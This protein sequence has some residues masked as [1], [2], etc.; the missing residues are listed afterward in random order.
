MRAL[1]R[2]IFVN[3]PDAGSRLALTRVTTGAAVLQT[4]RHLPPGELLD[5][6]WPAEDGKWRLSPG[7]YQALRVVAAISTAAWTLGAEHPLVKIVANTSFA[8]VQRHV[9]HFDQKAWN[10]NANLNFTLAALSLT[11]TRGSLADP[12]RAPSPE[13][14]SA[15]LGA[16][17][18]HYAWVYL[19]SGV[20]KL[21]VGGP[22][23][24]DGRTVHGS[25]AELGTPLGKRL[26]GTGRIAA[27]AAGGGSLAMELGYPVALLA[28]WRRKSWVGAAS[29]VFHSAVKATMDISFWHHATQALPLFVLPG[30]TERA[31]SAVLRLNP[32]RRA[33]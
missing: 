33:S 26:A 29:L 1:L 30:K 4:L 8:A 10:Y 28:L 32:S 18:A 5:R 6:H 22:G 20:A 24:L 25:W 3:Q 23:W 19:Q 13:V 7:Q 16:L 31:L 2:D 12:R 21:A 14:A 15:L 27:I 9:A 17:Q 11:D